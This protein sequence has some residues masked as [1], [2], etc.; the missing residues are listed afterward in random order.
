MSPWG[1]SW[2]CHW[3]RG[4]SLFFLISRRIRSHMQNGFNPLVRGLGGFDW[5][6]NR[7]SKISRQG[8]LR[9][10]GRNQLHPP[11]RQQKLGLQYTYSTLCSSRE[12]WLDRSTGRVEGVAV[13]PAGC[14]RVIG[15]GGTAGQHAQA[16]AHWACAEEH[17][18]SINKLNIL[19]L[20]QTSFLCEI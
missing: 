20:I 1:S 7:G 11:G 18:Q 15:G 13:G 17:C 4:D 9:R 14:S 3:P 16:L 2:R 19:N 12:G 5:R 10:R 6:K 8:P